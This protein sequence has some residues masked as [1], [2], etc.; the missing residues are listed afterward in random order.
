MKAL[1]C[2]FTPH[3][4]PPIQSSFSNF[5]DASPFG[6][7]FV[8]VNTVSDMGYAGSDHRAAVLRWREFLPKWMVGH[9]KIV[10][11]LQPYRGNSVTSSNYYWLPIEGFAPNQI[12]P[13]GNNNFLGTITAQDSYVKN[14][15]RDYETNFSVSSYLQSETVDANIVPNSQVDDQYL[16]SFSWKSEGKEVIFIPPIST[17]RIYEFLQSLQVGSTQW[18][19]AAT[20]ILE[21]QINQQDAQVQ[22]LEETKRGLIDNLNSVNLKVNNL[23]KMKFICDEQLIHILERKQPKTPILNTFTKQ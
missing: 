12:V 14:F 6:F 4:S 1:F 22:A 15:L 23:L 18:K 13:C 2:G 8:V 3:T 9:H 11:I 17:T 20:G 19:V 7:D 21:N 16:T 10:V 5:T